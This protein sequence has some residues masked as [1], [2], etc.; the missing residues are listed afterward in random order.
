[1]NRSSHKADQCLAIFGETAW[2][3]ADAAWFRSHRRRS[4]RMR[5]LF[6]GEFPAALLGDHERAPTHV[7]VCQ[8]EPGV[9][10]K[11]FTSKVVADD[12]DENDDDQLLGLWIT[13]RSSDAGASGSIM[14][15]SGVCQ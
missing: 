4:F 6:G 12:V 2:K 13:L 1:M 10:E 8:V 9:R 15:A 14:P 5:R 3:R 11:V 7:L